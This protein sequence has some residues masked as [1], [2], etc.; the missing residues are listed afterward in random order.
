MKYGCIMATVK[1]FCPLM[2]A[3]GA[4]PGVFSLVPIRRPN[5]SRVCSVRE[6]PRACLRR[7]SLRWAGKFASFPERERSE[8][9]PTPLLREVLGNHSRDDRLACSCLPHPY[10]C[11]YPT[12]PSNHCVLAACLDEIFPAE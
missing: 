3:T 12:V 7:V 10:Y 2:A 9:P 1:A 8:G 6:N 5:H 4:A 11:R